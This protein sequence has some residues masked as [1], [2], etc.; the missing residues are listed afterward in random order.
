MSDNNNIPEK[1][2]EREAISRGKAIKKIGVGVVA[3]S[4]MLL[5]L[6][7][8]AKAQGSVYPDPFSGF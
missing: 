3:G 6:Q 8:K 5:L 2:S 4:T 1:K 7:S